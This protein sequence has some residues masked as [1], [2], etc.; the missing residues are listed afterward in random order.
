[1]FK[2]SDDGGRRSAGVLSTA[3]ALLCAG[4][5][6]PARAQSAGSAPMQTTSA[7]AA[8]GPPILTIFDQTKPMGAQAA[9]GRLKP[10]PPLTWHGITLYGTVDAGLAYLNH[11]A[12]LSATYGAGLPFMIQK[13]SNR[14]EVSQFSNGLSQ[15]KIGVAIQ[16]PLGGGF[17]VVGRVETGFLPTSGRLYDGPASLLKNNGRSLAQYVEE[18]DSARA[19]QLINGRAYFGVSSKTFG[20]LTY[21]R[22]YSL[23]QDDL[24]VYDP[25]GQG[26]AVSPISYSGVAAGGGDT[27]DTIL[28]QTLKYQVGFGPAH[29][30]YL[31]Q[32]RSAG[33]IPRGADSVDVGANLFHGLSVDAVWSEVHDAIQDA[34]LSAAQNALDPGTLAATVSD[35]TTY[36]VMAKYTHSRY[37]LYA[38]WERIGYSNPSNPVPDGV[39]GIGGYTLGFVSDTAFDHH[40]DLQITWVGARYLVTDRLTVSGAYYNYIQNSYG[41]TDCSNASS[42]TCSGTFNEVSAVADY[43]FRPRWDIYAG[44]E[45]TWVT[46]GLASGYLQ[47]GEFAPLAGVR[48]NF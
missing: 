16:E 37:R 47:T 10:P 1:V 22:Q 8:A 17:S 39:V 4:L 9:A 21:G 43:R 19:G 27:E 2:L 32:F 34:T 6:K 40:K 15:S 13:F 38:G 25:Q 26:K 23:I 35:N 42:P 18:G 3:L 12:P 28:D 7:Q 36:A 46:N 24:Y 45:S 41:A 30:A 5:S 11:G 33:P 20:T 31:H 48:W 44:V 29:L 14:S